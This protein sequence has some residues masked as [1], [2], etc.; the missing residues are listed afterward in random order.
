MGVDYG[1]LID[2]Q[3]GGPADKAG[4][5]RYD[6]VVEI[7]GKKITNRYDLQNEV[8]AKKVGDTVPVV[9][10]RDGKRVQLNIKLGELE[11]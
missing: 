10:V 1:V 4:M 3:P 5:R 2:P 7:S 9:V 6:I 8:F 11:Q